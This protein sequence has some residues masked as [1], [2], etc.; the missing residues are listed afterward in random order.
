MENGKK[1]HN[2]LFYFDEQDIRI[3]WSSKIIQYTSSKVKYN[4][5][6]SLVHAIVEFKNGLT[7][8]LYHQT[9]MKIPIANALF[10][11]QINIKDFLIQD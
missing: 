10:G 9:S 11:S 3:N 7:K 8:F 1:N 6:R 2:W 5:S 4:P